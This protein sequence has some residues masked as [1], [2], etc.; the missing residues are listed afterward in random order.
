M[1]T[2]RENPRAKSCP[3][4][5]GDREGDRVATV[6]ITVDATVVIVKDVPAEVC[7][8]CGELFVTTEVSEIITEYVREMVQKGT[9]LTVV[10]F[11]QLERIP[12]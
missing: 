5:G 6:P 10:H 7:S 11:A 1:T 8:Q 4:C 12:A 9:E 2:E 3:F